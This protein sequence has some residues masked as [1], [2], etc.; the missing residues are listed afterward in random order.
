MDGENVILTEQ[1]AGVGAKGKRQALKYFGGF[2]LGVATLVGLF[3]GVK[4]LVSDDSESISQS[5][6]AAVIIPNDN[7]SSSTTTHTTLTTNSSAPPVTTATETLQII[8]EIKPAMLEASPYEMMNVSLV[9]NAYLT[10]KPSYLRSV[11]VSLGHN[12]AILADP[13]AKAFIQIYETFGRSPAHETTDAFA[14]I[15]ISTT[16]FPPHEFSAQIFGTPNTRE[17]HVLLTLDFSNH[18]DLYVP[19]NSIVAFGTVDD[20]DNINDVTV[21][22]PPDT[23][24]WQ[25][26]QALGSRGASVDRVV[27]DGN[28]NSVLTNAAT[29]RTAHEGI[30]RSLD[31]PLSFRPAW[32]YGDKYW[33]DIIYNPA[34][35]ILVGDHLS[36]LK[37]VGGYQIY[38]DTYPGGKGPLGPLL[39]LGFTD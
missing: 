33:F 28:T 32:R 36:N 31:S 39:E 14:V 17:S 16:V 29:I 8:N 18:Q 35:V 10:T 13:K 25:L 34:E 6:S 38:D 5:V 3:F 1:A 20:A 4:A 19:A 2:I 21:K 9:A 37:K 23:T 26:Y 11:R 30:A 22:F 7:N 15:P 12:S 24:D 27:K